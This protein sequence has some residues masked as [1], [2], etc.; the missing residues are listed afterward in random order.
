MKQERA[1][2]IKE[3]MLSQMK[4]RIAGR[5][6]EELYQVYNTEINP[7]RYRAMPCTCSPQPWKDMISETT[8]FVDRVLNA[9]EDKKQK[10]GKQ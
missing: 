9:W 1:K 2:Y 4:H 10:K 6:A 7:G 3:E 8:A 5:M